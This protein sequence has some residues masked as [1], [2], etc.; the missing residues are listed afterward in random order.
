M[1]VTTPFQGHLSSVG[2]DLL[3]STRIPNL[4]CL[5]LPATK[6]W[7]ATPNVKILVL[8]HPMGDFRVTYTVHLWL[9]GKRI[10]DFLLA[11]IELFSLALMAG[12]LLSEIYRNRRFLKGWVTLS[13]NLRQMWTANWTFS[14]AVTVEALWADIGQNFGVWKGGGS[15][16]AQILEG[17]GGRPPT[18]LV[19]RKLES[20][21]YHVVLFAWSYI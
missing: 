10:V 3:C 19:V 17:K 13:A 7:K 9:D 14:P 6:K 11:I 2:W 4:K 18:T 1:K 15:F 20:L 16:W 5:R 21:N 8:S 12:A